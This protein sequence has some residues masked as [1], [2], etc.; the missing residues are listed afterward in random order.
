[1]AK[2]AFQVSVLIVNWNGKTH[3]ETCLDAL[4]NQRDPGCPWRIWIFDNGSK[5]GSCEWLRHHHPQVQLME[6][7][8][9]L[10]FAEAVNRMAEAAEGDA[11]VFLNNDTRPHEDWLF[12]LVQS[13]RQAD[14]DVAAVAGM[15]VDWDEKT[16]DFAGG[17]LT[18]DGHAYQT[19]AGLPLH[20]VDMP[21][22]GTPL[23]FANGANMIVWRSVFQELGGFD[24]DF[25][26]YF[27]DVDF[28][29]R[30][31]AQGYR[32]LF[33]PGAI[34]RHRKQATSNRLG[35]FNRGV[36]F[37]RNA[38]LNAYKNFDETYWQALMP[39]IMMTLM[40][41]TQV[42]L[43]HRN[44]GGDTFGNL[45]FLPQPK[46]LK[47]LP[48][49][50]YRLSEFLQNAH[51]FGAGTLRQVAGGL[52]S[53]LPFFFADA[54]LKDPW[55]VAQFRAIHGIF[56]LLD[57]FAEKRHHQLSLRRKADVEIFRQFPLKI[58]E[59]Y[60]GDQTFFQSQGFKAML[61]NFDRYH[62]TFGEKLYEKE[63]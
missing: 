49:L 20:A 47:W 3:L 39:V 23:L 61:P 2:Q 42:L 62:L 19:A 21:Q 38:F 15:A 58:V 27:E 45:P 28:G 56:D 40:H 48:K 51:W 11:L 54:H 31:W 16:L 46:G 32:I 12:T 30:S 50:K 35:Q 33:E 17:A 5:D 43:E 14:P 29:W 57:Q 34:V 44:P 6:H 24:R 1:M 52:K 7:P 41:R 25:F 60:P 13:L 8:E 59:T 55:T 10:G 36:L 26:A 9:N 53:R 63:T 37:E 4:S 22:S 18:F